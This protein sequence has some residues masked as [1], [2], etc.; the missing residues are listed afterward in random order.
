ME[1]SRVYVA[2]RMRQ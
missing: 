1:K 2:P